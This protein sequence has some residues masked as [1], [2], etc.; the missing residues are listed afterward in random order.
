MPA[1]ATITIPPGAGRRV[2][3]AWVTL[4]TETSLP[5]LSPATRDV[6]LALADALHTASRRGVGTAALPT[7]GEAP[8]A[9]L[10]ALAG[11]LRDSYAKMAARHV[12]VA[13]PLAMMA[14]VLERERRRRAD[15]RQH[16]EGA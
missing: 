7:L 9:E 12:A 4:F 1:R 2:A 15:G 6:F 8:D 11:W 16:G 10:A 3:A 14:G 13:R 5:F